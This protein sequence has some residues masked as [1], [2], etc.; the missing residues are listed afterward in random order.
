MDKRVHKA[1]VLAIDHSRAPLP[2]GR[3]PLHRS[4]FL[5][6]GQNGWPRARKVFHGY[7]RQFL[8]DDGC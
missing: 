2:A 8:H 6:A 7:R 3:L 1:H 4:I 5:S